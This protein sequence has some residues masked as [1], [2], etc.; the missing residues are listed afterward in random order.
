MTPERLYQL[1]EPSFIDALAIDP[2][3]RSVTLD[4]RVEDRGPRLHKLAF[5]GVTRFLLD[6]PGNANW[7]LTELSELVVEPI[8]GGAGTWRF[9]AD[10]W[11]T[12]NLEVHA[13][14]IL[15]DGEPIREAAA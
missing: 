7:E 15:L 13:D 9:W 6:R 10:L 5:E 11:G 3:R 4:V 12:A 2:R 8:A 14:R 1:L